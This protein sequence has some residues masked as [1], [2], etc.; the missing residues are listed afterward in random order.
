MVQCTILGQSV[1]YIFFNKLPAL[2]AI[3]RML[4]GVKNSSEVA[5][6]VDDEDSATK[7][8][9]GYFKRAVMQLVKPGP[10]GKNALSLAIQNN[11]DICLDLMLSMS[12]QAADCGISGHLLNDF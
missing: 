6:I 11:A 1:F 8:D 4:T 12:L 10:D 7:F 9:Q 2:R 3:H 5:D